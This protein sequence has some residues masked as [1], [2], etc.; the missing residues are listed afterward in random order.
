MTKWEIYNE[1]W[2]HTIIKW[3]QYKV[4]STDNRIIQSLISVTI[5]LFAAMSKFSS[6]YKRVLRVNGAMCAIAFW[7]VSLGLLCRGHT[8]KKW[9]LYFDF[10]CCFADDEV[11]NSWCE[12]RAYHCWVMKAMSHRASPPMWK[13]AWHWLK[14]IHHH[15]L[16][17][18]FYWC[19]THYVI[20][21]KMYDATHDYVEETDYMM[22]YYLLL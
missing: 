11:C 15:Q 19:R 13:P 4:N 21:C 22:S 7:R 14:P 16:A 8:R 10:R 20:N 3:T 5:L 2:T 17:A 12:R 1:W 9:N 6:P 18:C